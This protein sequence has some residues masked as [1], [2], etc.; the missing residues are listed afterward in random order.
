MWK[1]GEIHEKRAQIRELIVHLSVE[2]QITANIAKQEKLAEKE[3]RQAEREKQQAEKEKPVENPVEKSVE[4][5][6]EKA[7]EKPVERIKYPEAR[8]SMK[9]VEEPPNP[10]APSKRRKSEFVTRNKEF[11][12]I[13]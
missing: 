4:K 9:R 12:E 13:E 6:V 5:P 11:I 2:W 3:K 7:V 10:P 8:T 1:G